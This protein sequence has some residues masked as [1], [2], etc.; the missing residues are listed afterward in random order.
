MIVTT[1][2]GLERGPQASEG[3]VMATLPARPDLG[4]LRREARDLL[5]AARSGDVPAADRIAA[6]SGALNLAAAQLAVAR[7]YGYA[8]WPR[9]KTAVEARTR[10][11]AE[12][13]RRFCEVSIRDW[14]GQAVRMLEAAPELAG[15]DFATALVLGDAERVRR[16]ITRDPDLVSRP[17]ERSGFTPLHAAC[18]S[19]WH[20][21][22]PA[23]ADG[24]T[25]VARLLLDT[26]AD[27]HGTAA[28]GGWTPLGCAVAGET[29]P[30]IVR[31]LLE[32]GAV[33]E[34]RDLYLAG[35]GGDN[36]ETLRL[37]LQH[38]DDV[39]GTASSALAAPI[40]NGDGEGVRL[41]LNA[42]ADPNKY[43]DDADEPAPVMYAAIRANTPAE[44]A[45]L[46]LSHG[47]DPAAPGPDGRSPYAFAVSKGR[48]D[49]ADL[50]RS[51]GAADDASAADKLLAA[52]LSG[53]LA[54]VRSYIE[55]EPGL[56]G[57]LADEQRAAAL[58]RAAET[59]TAAGLAVMLDLGFP[60]NARGELGATPLHTAAYAGSADVAELLIRRGADLEATDGN[61]N[62][63]PLD[64]ALVGS[65]E[66][67]D[68]NPGADWVRTVEVLIEAGASTA[69]I[70]LAP[71]DPK[72]PSAAVATYLRSRDIGGAAPAGE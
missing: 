5:R 66:Q 44:L 47:A 9:L 67:P 52:C 31:L 18:A 41:L 34:D 23:R 60:V 14:S 26:G 2:D 24:L 53:D 13:A 72:P 71:D 35:F 50:L 22:D 16:E 25:A 48:T 20:R 32:R 17:D 10:D 57:S 55:R 38:C 63:P 40:S 28:R 7:D 65:G 69:D 21:L 6:V 37:L 68:S 42:G 54:A 33:P 3:D 39:P 51:Y 36:H 61:W 59:G 56:L 64:W 19:R 46:L 43:S 45:E 4:H 29:N 70:T 58:A 30:A 11:L 49:L 1:P 15:Y 12:Q 27:P 62:S 8:S